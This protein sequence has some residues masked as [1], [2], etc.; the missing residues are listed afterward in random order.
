MP[1]KLTRMGAGFLLAWPEWDLAVAVDRLREAS[2]YTVTGEIVIRSTSEAVGGQLFRGRLNFTGPQAQAALIRAL[3][4][5][6]SGIVPSWPVVVSQ[7]VGGVLEALRQ[8]EPFLAAPD[9]RRSERVPYR[10]A[11]FL[12]ERQPTLIYG[13]GGT[14]KS[15][16]ALWWSMLVSTPVSENETGYQCEPGAVLYLD[17]ETDKDDFAERMDLLGQ[18]IGYGRPTSLYYR[19]CFRPLAADV[20]DLEKFVHEQE[21][22]LIIVDSAGLACGGTPQDESAVLPYFAALRQIGITSVTIAHVPKNA[23]HKTP[24]GSVYWTNMPR[25]V[26]EVKKVQEAG[27]DSLSIG[28]FHRKANRGRLQR[29]H[30]FDIRFEPEPASKDRFVAIHIRRRDVGEIPELASGLPLRE[31][32]VSVLKR[33]AL[34][35]EAIAEELDANLQR[36]RNVLTEHKGRSFVVTKTDGRVSYWGLLEVHNPLS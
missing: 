2:D 35:S 31:R 19:R 30:G 22:Q 9:M 10:L 17:Y 1:V 36:V 34:S 24:L 5:H 4:D 26:Y 15:M 27:D 32:I 7:L 29:P 25:S 33:G 13:D 8:G 18:G 11:P 3:N 16:I 23:E 14:G 21:I 12:L 6:H 20:A 28:L